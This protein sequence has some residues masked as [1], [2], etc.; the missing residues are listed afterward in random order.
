MPFEKFV[1]V[2]TINGERGKAIT[3]SIRMI[4][5]EDLKKLGE[6]SLITPVNPEVKRTFNSSAHQIRESHISSR[7]PRTARAAGV[8][9][10]TFGSRTK[11]RWRFPWLIHR[12]VLGG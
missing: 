2:E 12:L 9:L 8:S 1:D 7:V 3:E 10:D 11:K 5:V 6:I 4:R